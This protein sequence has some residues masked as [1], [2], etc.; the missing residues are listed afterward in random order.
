MEFHQAPF[1]GDSSLLSKEEHGQINDAFAIGGLRERFRF[2][3]G[4]EDRFRVGDALLVRSQER[5]AYSGTV[6]APAT[7]AET[8]AESAYRKGVIDLTVLLLA[9]QQ[10]ITAERRLVKFQVTAITD[11]I[12]LQEQ[13]GGSFDL[14]PLPPVVPDI[15]QATTT[16]DPTKTAVRSSSRGPEI[17]S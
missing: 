8:L 15:D 12:S 16:T 2:R 5:F 14:S 6:L 13:V 1:G 17:Q 11:R 3:R 4:G 7:E 10:R 9:Q